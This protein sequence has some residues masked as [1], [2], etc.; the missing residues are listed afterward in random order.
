MYHVRL[1]FILITVTGV[2][3]LGLSVAAINQASTA[4]TAAEAVDK[5]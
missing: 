1:M 3:G 5:R 4:Q 2:L